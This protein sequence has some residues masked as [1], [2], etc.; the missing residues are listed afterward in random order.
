MAEG[1]NKDV[2]QRRAGLGGL[3]FLACKTSPNNW[4]QPPRFIINCVRCLPCATHC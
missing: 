4:A 2:R 3:G 1:K